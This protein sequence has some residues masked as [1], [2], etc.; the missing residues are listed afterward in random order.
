MFTYL[1]FLFIIVIIII[2]ISDPSL[3]KGVLKLANRLWQLGLTIGSILL[4]SPI[5]NRMVLKYVCS[6]SFTLPFLLA[7]NLTLL[8]DRYEVIFYDGFAKSVRGSKISKMKESDSS[9][10]SFFSAISQLIAISASN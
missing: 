10:S 2:I 5:T 6:L 3:W 7:N 1:F 9:V 8:T 4:L